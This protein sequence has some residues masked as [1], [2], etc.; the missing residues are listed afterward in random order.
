MNLRVVATRSQ[1]VSCDDTN[2]APRYVNVLHP[3]C[4]E[5]TEDEGRLYV[6][7]QDSVTTHTTHE[8]LEILRK[9]FGDCVISRGSHVLLTYQIVAFILIEV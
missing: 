8:C 9:V 7:Q 3:F 5:L 1:S 2:N 6:S 4:A